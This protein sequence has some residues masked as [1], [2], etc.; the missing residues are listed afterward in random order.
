MGF[1]SGH[2]AK[3]VCIAVSGKLSY[4]SS[5]D[6]EAVD[7][8]AGAWLAEMALWTQW[9]HR[10]QLTA[11]STTDL[12]LLNC[13]CFQALVAAAGGPVLSCLQKFALFFVSHVED[14]PTWR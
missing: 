5:F 14:M 13:G 1:L 2:E 12:A 6:D 11:M 7:V 10:G 4:A 3:E 9:E 8:S